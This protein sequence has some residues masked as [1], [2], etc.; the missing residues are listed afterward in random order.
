[1]AGRFFSMSEAW[2]RNERMARDMAQKEDMVPGSENAPLKT[3]GG[4]EFMG[5]DGNVYQSRSAQLRED[6]ALGLDGEDFHMG[7]EH[8]TKLKEERNS[9]GSFNVYWQKENGGTYVQKWEKAATG[10]HVSSERPRRIF[11]F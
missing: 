5:K 9:D 4:K 3:V 8:V 7:G 2:A 1:M 10:R 6:S 11:T